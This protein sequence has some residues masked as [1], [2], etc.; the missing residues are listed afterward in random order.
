MSHGHSDQDLIRDSHNTARFFTS[1]RH[2]AWVLLIGTVLWGIY[3]YQRMPRR[4]DPD[5]PVRV[6][7]AIC[8]WPGSSAERIEQLVTRRIEEKIA[9]NP[10]IEKLESVTRTSVSV[11][12]VTIG[13]ERKDRA[14]ELDDLQLKLNSLSDLPDGAGPI[15]FLKDFGDTAALMLTVASP[16]PDAIELSVRADAIRR[17]IAGARQ[18]RRSS[19]AGEPATV[20]VGYPTALDPA[21]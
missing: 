10:H 20:I 1:N 5:I 8:P 2:V 12:Y 6:A 13:Q 11:V 9:E 17:S 18:A 21:M 19:A 16:R 7:V 15:Q 3:G 14:R 4:K